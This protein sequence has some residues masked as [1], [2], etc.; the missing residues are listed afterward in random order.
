M[1]IFLIKIDHELLN[2][3]RFFMW[4]DT[5]RKSY[6]TYQCNIRLGF[7]EPED[8]PYLTGKARCKIIRIPHLRT[9]STL[10]MAQSLRK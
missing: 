8:F 9:H 5:V 7:F 3:I 10:R 6:R 1:G 4:I 2:M